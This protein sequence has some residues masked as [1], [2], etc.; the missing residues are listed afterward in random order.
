MSKGVCLFIFVSYFAQYLSA[1]SW[2]LA[3]PKKLTKDKKKNWRQ[4]KSGFDSTKSGL[5]SEKVREKICNSAQR[6]DITHG[7]KTGKGTCSNLTAAW[8]PLTYLPDSPPDWLTKT[9][10]QAAGNVIEPAC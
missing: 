3:M 2:E 7:G 10:Q 4:Q 9:A 6:R 1:L 8:T 5:G